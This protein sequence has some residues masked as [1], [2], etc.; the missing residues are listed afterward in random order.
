MMAMTT[1][2]STSVNAAAH[3]Q[4]GESPR[5]WTV[6]MGDRLAIRLECIEPGIMNFEAWVTEPQPA[7]E[8]VP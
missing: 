6:A 1:S 8:S 4:P 2:N 5:L 7:V 3:R